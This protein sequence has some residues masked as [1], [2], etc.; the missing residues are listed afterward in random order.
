M[1]VAIIGSG[2]AGLSAG[3]YLQKAGFTTDI[4]E[5]H[6][7]VGGLC[8]SW[9]RSGFSFNGCIHWVLGARPGTSFYH[10]WQE[11]A[12]IDSLEWFMPDERCVFQLP[13]KDCHGSD[14]FHYYTDINRFEEYLLSIAPADRKPISRWC[15]AVR[16]LIPLLDF[17]PPVFP[18]GRL[19]RFVFSLGLVRL[20]PLLFFMRRWGRLSNADF[21]NEFSS[22]FLREAICRLYDSPMRMTVLLFAQAYAAKGVAQYPLGGSGRFAHLLADSYKSLGGS[23]HL[24]SPVASV[25]TERN[26][27]VGLS[28]H[29]GSVVNAD[30]VISCADWHWTV[31]DALGARFTNADILRLQRPSKD[32]VFYSYCRLFLGVNCPMSS[33]PHFGRF[34]VPEFFLPDGTRFDHLEVEVYNHDPYLAPSGKVT[35]VVNLLT[36]EG[37]WWIN[38]RND[39][40]PAYL[41]AKKRLTDVLLN[42]LTAHYGTSWRTAVEVTDLVTPATFHRYTHNLRGSSQGWT[43][44]DDITRRLPIRSTL[45]GLQR[46][47]MAGHWLE[48]GGG[49]PVALYS[50]RQVA[51]SIISDSH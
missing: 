14:L 49:I 24:S 13:V 2:V 36:R 8:T 38:L 7:D 12:D 23:L 42:L 48:A 19:K 3:I 41:T 11:V 32:S 35:M 27:A 6:S 21:A 34:L 20:T 10:F 16:F 28:L 29:D 40:R 26:R 51:M 50:A 9:Q 17:L 43:P 45:P 39:D 33:E 4:F 47:Y 46:F 15:S 5:A 22:P 1:K 44:L 25:R 37:Q 30:Y 31:F 18:T